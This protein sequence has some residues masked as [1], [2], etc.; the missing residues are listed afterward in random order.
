MQIKFPYTISNG[1]GE[2]IRFLEIIPEPDG[3][4]LIGEN[5]VA[6]DAGPPM[7]VHW[8]QD[9]GFTVVS[10][11]IGYQLMGGPE[12]YASAGESIV[13]KRGVA[14]RFWNAG[15][16][17]LRCKAWV[18][19]AD[20]FVF[21]ITSLFNSAQKTG[22][23]RPSLWDSS[24][25]LQRYRT[26]FDMPGLPFVLRKFLIPLVYFTGKLLGKFRHFNDA[27]APVKAR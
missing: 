20:N 2:L 14:H 6:P 11:R 21:Y 19:P 3:D 22:T 26:E 7:H 18:K 1:Q 8:L 13:F 16:E 27:P 24:F 17:T 9:E 12:Q 15:K 5:E 10:G 4:K 25:L 23:G